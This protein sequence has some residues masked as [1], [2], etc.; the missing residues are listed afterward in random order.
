MGDFPMPAVE[1]QLD[2]HTIHIYCV[3][4]ILV[5]GKYP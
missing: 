4:K 3:N 5:P 2:F 1:T